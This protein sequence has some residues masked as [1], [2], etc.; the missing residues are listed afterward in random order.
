MTTGKAIALG[1]GVGI[2]AYLALITSLTLLGV[3]IGELGRFPAYVGCL[4]ELEVQG[5]ETREPCRRLRSYF[6]GGDGHTWQVERLAAE[7]VAIVS[8]LKT[9]ARDDLDDIDE[10][11]ITPIARRLETAVEVAKDIFAP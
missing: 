10:A 7:S 3:K 6:Q 11:W 8:R 1:V 9:A 5:A 2:T 4:A